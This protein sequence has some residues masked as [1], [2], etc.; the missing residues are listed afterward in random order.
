MQNWLKL[1]NE[2]KH[3]SCPDWRIPHMLIA[4]YCEIQIVY[5][6]GHHRPCSGQFFAPHTVHGCPAS[7]SHRANDHRT[8]Y[9]FSNFWPSGLTIGPKFT[10]RGDD[11]LCT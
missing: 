6:S 2:N 4:D 1:K 7:L 10:K 9:R 3:A 5:N 8:C 11:L